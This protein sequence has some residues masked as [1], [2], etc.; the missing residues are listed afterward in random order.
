MWPQF[1]LEARLGSIKV[2]RW[3]TLQKNRGVV[4]PMLIFSDA[5]YSKFHS[6]NYPD[7]L[8]A[9]SCFGST[10]ALYMQDHG[11]PLGL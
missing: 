9:R 11:D 2:S 5:K 7:V 6:R 8:Q 4:I 3:S 1:A 10:R